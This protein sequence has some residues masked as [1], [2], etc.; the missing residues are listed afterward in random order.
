MGNNGL[1]QTASQ[2]DLEPPKDY[3]SH[4]QEWALLRDA[5]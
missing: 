2:V 3:K 1:K 5:H 4:I